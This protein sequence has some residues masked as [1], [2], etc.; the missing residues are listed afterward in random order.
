MSIEALTVV[1]NHSQARGTEKLVLI[2]IANHYGEQGAWPSVK[3]LASY[4]NMS[5]RRVQQAIKALQSSGELKVDRGQGGGIGR[6]KTN[7][8]SL[9]VKCPQDCSGFPQ[10]SQAKYVSPDPKGVQPVSP[11]G[12]AHFA[13]GVKHNVPEP[14]KE[15]SNNLYEPS[16]DFQ[17]EL[18][19]KFPGLDI[20]RNADAF[21]DWMKA[22]GKKYKD[23]DAAFRNWVRKDYEWNKPTKIDLEKDKQRTREW[24]DSEKR[25][26][27][28]IPKCEHGNT[29]ALC[30]E[31]LRG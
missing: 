11:Q 31:C 16:E 22:N 24:L 21:N 28:E 8:Y 20:R 27:E 10:H 4:S 12:E 3:T 5:E 2:G 15:T 23:Y 25:V 13:P 14:V 7:L 18:L 6:Y 30:K 1:L 29:I 9:N 19:L 17:K 26:Y